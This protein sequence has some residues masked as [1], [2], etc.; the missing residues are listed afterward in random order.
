[1]KLLNPRGF[2]MVC[3]TGAIAIGVV[4]AGCANRV[5]GSAGPN[6]DDLAAYKTEAASSSAAATSSRRAAAQAKAIADNCG[7]FPTTTGIGVT[8]YNEFVDAHDANAPDYT[9]KRDAAAQTLEDAANTVESGVNGARD[10]LPPDLAAKF[11]EYVNAARALAAE[12]RTMTYLAPVAAL[13][14]AS[15]RVNDARNAVRDSCPRR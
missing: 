1:M 10:T 8:R 6:A 4:V 9:A 12:T 14:D 7:Q 2:G 5:E 11:T 3:A 15:K 13:N